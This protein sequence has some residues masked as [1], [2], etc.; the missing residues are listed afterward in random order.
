MPKNIQ[1][2]IEIQ[3][4][5]SK[6][7]PSSAL[8]GHHVFAS[9]ASSPG[10]V[11]GSVKTDEHGKGVLKL[12]APGE[13]PPTI[14]LTLS[15][16]PTPKPVQRVRNEV[17]TF[18]DWKGDTA[19]GLS[20]SAV[21]TP[22]GEFFRCVDWLH[23]Q[24]TVEGLL[25]AHYVDV[26]T[27]IGGEYP[28][29]GAHVGLY[30][31]DRNYGI[32]C[33]PPEVCLPK[34]K[35][36]QAIC[37]PNIVCGPNI[38]CKP[39]VQ[40][41]CSPIYE[42]ICTPSVVMTDCGPTRFDRTCGPGLTTIPGDIGNIINPAEI[43]QS[44]PQ[45][46]SKFALKSNV[47]SGCCGSETRA[48]DAYRSGPSF[49]PRL[50]S[51]PNLGC[52]PKELICTPNYAR[53]IIT[54]SESPLGGGEYLTGA[55]GRFWFTF[56]RIDFFWAPAGTT[57]TEDF[58]WDEFPDLVF[59]ARLWFDGADHII[60]S[61]KPADARWNI[62][63]DYSFFKLVVQGK[64]PGADAPD[65]IN[66]GQTDA[67]LFHTVG[68][69]EPG[70]IDGKGVI[71]TPATGFSWA[72]DHVFGGTLEIRGQFAPSYSDGLHYY[73]VEWRR[74][75]SG[76]WTPVTGEIWYYSRYDPDTAEWTTLTRAP[77]DLGG[78][79]VACYPIPDYTD[80]KIDRKDMVMVWSTWRM[81]GNVPRYPD[82]M[83]QLRVQLIRQNG[84]TV[85]AE[86]SFEPD[87]Q[88]LTL[89]IDN[90][91][92]TADI[93]TT[94]QLATINSAGVLSDVSNVE[95]CGFVNAGANRYLILPFTL[96]DSLGGKLCQYSS[97]V[98]RG[99]DQVTNLTSLPAAWTQGPGAI[100]VNG[101]PLIP[102]SQVYADGDTAPNYLR[103]C[104]A[105]ALFNDPWLSTPDLKP[106]AYN[107]SI[108]VYDRATNG[109]AHVHWYEVRATL[110]I[111]GPGIVMP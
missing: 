61:E 78:D 39:V 46:T 86:P 8:S 95:T 37:K 85:E 15:P 98:N 23:E 100:T 6:E 76:D 93:D 2:Q 11:L 71:A 77:Q 50:A 56:R 94:L 30:E 4:K 3:L 38:V 60:Y 20:G 99:S 53:P 70:W 108:W 34:C 13:R 18:T 82:G 22:S 81:D 102:A 58:D 87:A 43:A 44:I 59:Q 31:V 19:K 41:I 51:Y 9:P 84:S 107:F 111:L 68:D 54:Y 79:F 49:S 25:V 29:R 104:V 1:M 80:Q 63:T 96:A 26:E 12:V 36:L 55:D 83:F 35:P 92:P 28:I 47:T 52:P 90:T 74:G 75:D 89:T 27:G 101:V 64:V 66:L 17:L 72:K 103:G 69:I 7:T 106:C 65:D 45:A 10:Q 24:F 32:T 48:A 42:K 21:F 67:F 73:Q 5:A 109:Y 16:L 97:G 110:T 40:P 105:F 33:K 88:K 57:H 62:N 14:I 91:W